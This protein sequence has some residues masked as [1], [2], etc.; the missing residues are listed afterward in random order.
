MSVIQNTL[1]IMPPMT[2]LIVR[3]KDKR[4]QRE[5]VERKRTRRENS[6]K[7]DLDKLTVEEFEEF[8][9]YR[10]KKREGKRRI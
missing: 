9:Q 6:R 5:K 7:Y 3:E 2:Y 4:C 10:K 8:E 1:F